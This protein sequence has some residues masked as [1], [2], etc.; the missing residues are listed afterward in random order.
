MGCEILDAVRKANK[1]RWLICGGGCIKG[2]DCLFTE[3]EAAFPRI[4]VTSITNNVF[5]Q[6]NL[7]EKSPGQGK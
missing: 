6:S 7:S 5:V 1:N 2:R 4:E 3:D